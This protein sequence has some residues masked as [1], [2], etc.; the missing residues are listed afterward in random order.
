[1]E[2]DDKFRLTLPEH[3]L[4]DHSTMILQLKR[5]VS[6]LQHIIGR[7]QSEKTALVHENISL[8]TKC[9]TLQ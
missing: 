8:S 2:A 9:D 5:D 4:P 6:E 3:D 1:M 7:L